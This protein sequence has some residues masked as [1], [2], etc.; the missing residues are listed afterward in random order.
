MVTDRNSTAAGLREVLDYLRARIKALP[1]LVRS[2]HGAQVPSRDEAIVDVVGRDD[3]PL[4]QQP[5]SGVQW[6][7]PPDPLSKDEGDTTERIPEVDEVRPTAQPPA[8]EN[9]PRG[10]DVEIPEP[11]AVDGKDAPQ[12]SD[13]S[14]KE[15]LDRLDELVDVLA[16]WF[17]AEQSAMG[18][19][20]SA[21]VEDDQ[22]DPRVLEGVG[23]PDRSVE[24]YERFKPTI[25]E[26][27]GVPFV[28]TV[29]KDG[30]SA[31][32]DE[33]ECSYTYTV[34]DMDGSELGTGITPQKPRYHYV[35]YWYAGETR[36]APAT[37]TSTYGLACYDGTT[38][39]LLVA[40]GE[41]AKDDACE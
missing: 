16:S 5:A 7:E 24:L 37:A 19:L 8:E 1:R 15:A 29:V 32:S 36:T 10:M 26:H 39:V 12:S 35:A 4:P 14:G 31:G 3:R 34:T 2:G 41:I 9:D 27:A 6:P 23:Q 33:E 25:M 21:S 11:P 13:T 22:E 20:D 17:D 18:A 28:V 38:L 30:G 40:Y